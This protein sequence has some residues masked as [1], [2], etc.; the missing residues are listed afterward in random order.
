MRFRVAL[1]ALA[2]ITLPSTLHASYRISVW[3]QRNTA[4][5][6]AIRRHAGIITE[7]NPVFYR[8]KHDGTAYESSAARDPVY[9]SALAGTETIPTF[10]NT[11]YYNG[12][13]RPDLVVSY[14]VHPNTRGASTDDIVSY[15]VNRGW[16]GADIDYENV[17]STAKND[18]N[19]FIELL[20]QKLHANG[21]KLSVCVYAKTKDVTSWDPPNGQDWTVLSQHADFIKIMAYGPHSQQEPNS[22]LAYLT[23]VLN[24][25]KTKIS[26]HKKIIIGIPWYAQ[27]YTPDDG[28]SDTSMEYTSYGWDQVQ[29]T[30]A[31]NPG[32]TPT[33]DASSGEL[34]FTYTDSAG[35]QH[36]IWYTD[37]VTYGKKVQHVIQ[38]HPTIGGFAHWAAG[39]EDPKVYGVVQQL[40]PRWEFNKD[41]QHDVVLRDSSLGDVRLWNIND[42][43]I[44]TN[45]L[46]GTDALFEVAAAGHFTRDGETDLILR[47]PSNGEVKLWQMNNH[48]VA[49][50]LPVLTASDLNWKIVAAADIT[51]D[52]R[53]EII[54]HH[55]TNGNA[56]YWVRDVSTGQWS[57]YLMGTAKAPSD[58]VFAGTADFNL[59]GRDDLL[60]RKF[61]NGDNELWTMNGGT[62][63]T[64]GTILNAGTAWKVA[65]IGDFN[66]DLYPDILWRDEASQQNVL[67]FMKDRVYQ[68]GGNITNAYPE[69]KV[70]RVGDFN[71]DDYA[72]ILWRSVN[73]GTV[74]VW[75]MS[76]LTYLG[77]GTVGS[78]GTN[79]SIT[80]K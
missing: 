28:D 63:T 31:A 56:A 29:S 24:Y 80:A 54:W 12:S 69:W 11:D 40:K 20:A 48:T 7:S 4:S 61:T 72:D 50:T 9:L 75:K 5:S 33:R 64:S 8:L 60:W 78:P 37:A 47:N 30:L 62:V 14:I 66:R 13:W 58:W 79:W 51:G 74:V 34:T 21:K 45:T 32:I 26:D 39:L 49:A 41:G 59:D 65:G 17:P 71:G 22:T 10:Q 70:V 25:A 52:G 44:S 73:S 16:A 3:Q 15:V 43:T 53:H 67:W 77:G 55:Q 68:S 2:L 19:A 76:G 23:S 18:F 36:W 6:E 57:G 42:G 38:N 46:V 35:L 27:D 1:F